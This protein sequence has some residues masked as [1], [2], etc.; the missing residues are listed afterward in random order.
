MITKSQSKKIAQSRLDLQ[1]R[2]DKAILNA[3]LDTF[4]SIADKVYSTGITPSYFTFKRVM[5]KGVDIDGELERLIKKLYQILLDNCN[6]SIML[7]E[8]KYKDKSDILAI[9]ILES[10]YK[11]KNATDRLNIAVSKFKEDIEIYIAAGLLYGISK[12]SLNKNAPFAIQ[13]PYK[14][15][16]VIRAFNDKSIKTNVRG[17]KNRGLSYGTGKYRH[18]YTDLARQIKGTMSIVFANAEINLMQKNGIIGYQVF[19]GSNYP[20]Q[21]CDDNTG[22]HQLIDGMTLPVHDH[23]MCYAVPVYME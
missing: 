17:I 8:K 15:A 20:C 13:N 2:V 7:A 19:R 6:M 21:A 22:F 11:G 23:C 9:S 12:K 18:G 16:S 1:K 5:E 3:L 4:N 14:V 10:K